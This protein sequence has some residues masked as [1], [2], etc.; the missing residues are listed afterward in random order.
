MIECSCDENS[1]V[2]DPFGGAGTTSLVALQLGHRAITIDVHE[3]YTQEA[4]RRLA[5]APATYDQSDVTEVETPIV[6][7][8]T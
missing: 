7:V 8:E 1:L 4:K 6:G 5:N 3:P 2:L